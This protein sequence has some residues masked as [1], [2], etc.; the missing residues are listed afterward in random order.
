MNAPRP[1]VLHLASLGS[2]DSSSP[3]FFT[4]T[5][6][7]THHAPSWHSHFLDAT[8]PVRYHLAV[9]CD[10]LVLH[11]CLD[12]SL[13]PL[14]EGRRSRGLKTLIEWN[15]AR[16]PAG[17]SHDKIR[18]AYTSP[19]A[20]QCRDQFLRLADGVITHST[21]NEREFR[22]ITPAPVY[23]LDP[24][25][26]EDVVGPSFR[27]A[28]YQQF[29]LKRPTRNLYSMISATPT[30]SSADRN[31]MK[32][33]SL[34]QH[35]PAASSRVLSLLQ[36]ARMLWKGGARKEA[37]T[38]LESSPYCDI[39]DVALVTA[40]CLAKASPPL[41]HSYLDFCRARFTKDLRFALLQC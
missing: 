24:A 16:A 32:T 40:Y 41:V 11:E 10:L 20:L 38:V 21:Q 22:K 30:P 18:A 34:P 4:M 37:L 3:P 2:T 26:N 6:Q 17:A 39:P 7:I 25:E 1:I 29:L 28:L 36:C 15:T 14:V 13:S 31:L 19:L 35:P 9:A 5:Q 23:L 8:H 27:I 12:W 33:S